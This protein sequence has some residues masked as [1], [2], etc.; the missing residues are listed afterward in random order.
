MKKMILL[1]L[2]MLSIT[3]GGCQSATDSGQTG[4]LEV[5]VSWQ[6]D[7]WKP[8]TQGLLVLPDTEVTIHKV[9]STTVFQTGTTDL[10]GVYMAPDLPVGWYWIEAVHRPEGIQESDFGKHWVAHMIQIKP[11]KS[12]QIDFDFNNAGGWKVW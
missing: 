11:N 4:T 2:L 7:V 3:I 9:F 12:K 5:H 8:G 1:I 6:T 10:L